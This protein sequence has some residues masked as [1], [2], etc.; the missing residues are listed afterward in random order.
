MKQTLIK[1]AFLASVMAGSL[2]C[3]GGIDGGTVISSNGYRTGGF[4]GVRGAM[5]FSIQSSIIGVGDGTYLEDSHDG[6]GGSFGIQIGGQ[7]GQWRATLGYEYFDNDEP[8]NFDLFFSE[9]DYFFLENPRAFQPYL[10]IVGG[11]LS[12]ET[13]Y[14]EDSGG[15]AYGASAGVN[16]NLSDNIDLDLSLRYLFATQDEVDHVGSV[17]F[18][19]N[20]FY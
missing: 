3:A 18:A 10:G 16:F 14:A 15:F 17:N 9:V 8:Q 13:S 12:Y 6:S 5:V 7:E 19:I 11:Y 2:L 20:Y 4:I 1:K